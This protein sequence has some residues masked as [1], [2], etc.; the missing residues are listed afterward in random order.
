M[1]NRLDNVVYS[2][3]VNELDR[4]QKRLK[5]IEVYLKEQAQTEPYKTPVD[6]LRCFRGIDTISAIILIAE[7]FAFERF[8]T[9]EALMAYIGLVPSQQSSGGKVIR[10]G[11]TKAGNRRVRSALIE[12]AWHQSGKPTVGKTLQARRKGQEQWVIDIADKCME[13]M[14]KR[15]WHLINKGKT[16]Q[17]AIVALSREML[18]FIWRVLHTWIEIAPDEQA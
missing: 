12:I 5:D 16:K 2:N 7:M 3:Y 1:G 10:G 18:G 11:I 14:Y 8:D 15:Y 6:W 13:R 17:C 9:P 4:R